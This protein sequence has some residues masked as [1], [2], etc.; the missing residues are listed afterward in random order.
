MQG[1]LEVGIA[2]MRKGLEQQQFGNE[3]CYRT[4]CYCSLAKA[5]GKAG[6]PEGGLSALAEALAQVEKADER[7]SEAEIYRVKG[8]LLL[9]QGHEVEAEANLHEAIGV[10][11]RQQAKSWELRATTSLARLWQVQGRTDEARQ[12]LSEIYG[13]FTEGFD[14]ADLIEAKALLD[15][16]A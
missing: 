13:W 6:R 1:H 10:A 7:Y 2:E 8:E 3:Q 4:G 14:T 12:M 15:E 11:R 5:Q 9:A 16:L